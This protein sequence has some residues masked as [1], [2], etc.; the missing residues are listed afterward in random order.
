MVL[1]EIRGRHQLRL[2]PSNPV[3]NQGNLCWQEGCR[4]SLELGQPPVDG[5]RVSCPFAV[6]SPA[7]GLTGVIWT[8]RTLKT[9]QAAQG[10]VQRAARDLE[11]GP[12]NL[13]ESPRHPWLRPS[14]A[15]SLRWHHRSHRCSHRS[16][17][18]P[19]ALCTPQGAPASTRPRVHPPLL[20]PRWLP[21]IDSDVEVE[22]RVGGLDEALQGLGGVAALASQDI[23]HGPHL[24]GQGAR[25]LH[26]G[27]LLGRQEL[28]PAQVGDDLLQELRR[29]GP[30]QLLAVPVDPGP[31][32]TGQG[33]SGSW[34]SPGKV[35]EG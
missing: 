19:P 5:V 27:S 24:L 8:L 2:E 25:C 21:T 26:L 9:P 18:H 11:K 14:P 12:P 23:H 22:L 28:Q 34:A 6:P 20:A 13:A 1:R 4:E 3:G 35:G 33:T 32:G 15:E 7:L 17:H 29:D 31:C 10:G 16:C 30:R